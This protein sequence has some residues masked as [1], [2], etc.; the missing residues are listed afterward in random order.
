MKNENGAV[1]IIVALLLT[2]FIALSALV[3][4]IGYAYEMRRQLQSAA[5]AAALAAMITKI[6]GGDPVEEARTYAS[7]NDLV[8][9]PFNTDILDLPHSDFTNDSYVKVGVRKQ[10]DFFFAPLFNYFNRMIY[11]QA[12]AKRVY[13]TGARGLI[14]WGVSI[15]RA[16]RAVATVNGVSVELTYDSSTES[17]EGSLPVPAAAQADGYPVDLTV[18][19]GQ[20]FPQTFAGVA[21]IVVHPAGDIVTDVYLGDNTLAAAQATGLYVAAP[22]APKAEVG[23]DRYSEVDFTLTAP[24]LYRAVITAPAGTAPLTT[25]PVNVRLDGQTINNAARLIVTQTNSPISAIDLGQLHFA[26]GGG[27]TPIRVEIADFEYGLSYRLKVVSNPETGNFNALD[28]RYIYHPTDYTWNHGE[29]DSAADYYDNLAAV[30]PGAVHIGDIITTKTGNLSGPQTMNSLDTRIIDCSLTLTCCPPCAGCTFAQWGAAGKPGGC[31]KLI[32]V[33]IVERI[34]RITGQSDVE[35]I[36]IAVF[37]LENYE[38]IGGDKID[39]TG[40]FIE[41]ARVGSYSDTPPDSGLYMETVRLD[42]PDY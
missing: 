15:I 17:W 9:T 18:Y 14:P 16:T 42:L 8:G 3:A 23:G 6:T 25:F 35:V 31:K 11:A 10:A 2:V 20:D 5:D 26:A 40:R 37:F 33:P 34:E 19:N 27:S 39:I 29:N 30:Y 7:Q 13:V 36:A 12:K 41:Y 21:S 28:F 4:D 38:K 24:N 22:A 1:A 32:Y